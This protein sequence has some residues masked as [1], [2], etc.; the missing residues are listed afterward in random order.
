MSCLYYR[1][2]D[3]AR[4]TCWISFATELVILVLFS[5]SETTKRLS[6]MLYSQRRKNVCAN[7]SRSCFVSNSPFSM[8]LQKQMGVVSRR[9]FS[10][11]E[12]TWL[13]VGNVALKIIMTDLYLIYD[14]CSFFV[15]ASSRARRH[16]TMVC[17][18][19]RTKWASMR[20]RQWLD[21]RE[22][23]Q[24]MDNNPTIVAIVSGCFGG[25]HLIF[26]VDTL[27][28]HSCQEQKREGSATC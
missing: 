3:F 28:S 6:F 15:Q 21:I 14:L 23:T 22:N 1:I 4:N 8:D 9:F 26:R 24:A 7:V 2:F 12:S 5:L 20:V 11:K 16:Q 19:Q 13:M 17:F 18:M 27:I 10:T 25:F